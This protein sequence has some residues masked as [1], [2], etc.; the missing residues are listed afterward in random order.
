MTT[1]LDRAAE[2]AAAAEN[3]RAFCAPLK[4][5]TDPNLAGQ[6]LIVLLLAAFCEPPRDF[7][8]G[9]TGDILADVLAG[10]R[11]FIHHLDLDASEGGGGGAWL[12][13]YDSEI[14]VRM[15]DTLLVLRGYER[16]HREHLA[17]TIAGTAEK[18]GAK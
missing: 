5:T 16:I 2:Y 4:S 12:H 10:V 13:G 1:D 8:E 15:L 7:T 11:S 3:W 14:L 6:P 17:R 18:G 9:W